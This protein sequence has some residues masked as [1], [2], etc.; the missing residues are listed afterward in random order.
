MHCRI[1]ELSMRRALYRDT[2]EGTVGF[3]PEEHVCDMMHP[4]NLGHRHGAFILLTL[5]S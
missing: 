1:P 3:K 5:E 4:N 2:M